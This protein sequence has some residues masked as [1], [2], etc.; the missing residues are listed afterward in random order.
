MGLASVVLP[1]V[2]FAILALSGERRRD[3][4]TALAHPRPACQAG[5]IAVEALEEDPGARITAVPR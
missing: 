4:C 3:A 1:V 5:Q 2:G